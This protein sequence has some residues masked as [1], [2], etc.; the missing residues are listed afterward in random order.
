MDITRTSLRVL[1]LC[2]ALLHVSSAVADSVAPAFAIPTEAASATVH[3][4]EGRSIVARRVAPGAV[5]LDGVMNET[6]W[7]QAAP[8]RELRR[9]RPVEDGRPGLGDAEFRL[10]YDRNALY[11]G[12]RVQQP[13]G[14]A[15][16]QIRPRDD[17][18]ND[19]S[20]NIYLKSR[21]A[22]GDGY[23]FRINPLGIKKDIL[24]IGYD[25]TFGSWD[26]VW[27]AATSPLPAG[28]QM[29]VR[30]PFR[31]LR[32][33]RDSRNELRIG[34]GVNSGALGQLDL[35][36]RFSSERAHHLDQLGELLG[37]D[38]IDDGHR[39]DILPSVVFRYG[40]RGQADDSFAFDDS[41]VFRLRRPG[42]I[43]LGLD[44]LYQM[45]DSV[46]MGLAL[47]PD[48]SQV[49]ADPDQ[50]DYNLR[51]PL[52]LEETRPFFL[53]AL[54]TFDTPI[55]LLYT[56]S[57][58]DPVAG[59]R[60]TGHLGKTT[61]SL[62]SAWDLDPP[63]SRIR[64]DPSVENPV[65][66]GFEAA[67]EDE[68]F[69]TVARATVDLSRT[70]RVGAFFANKHLR[71]TDGGRDANNFLASVD[72]H[73]TLGNNYTFTGQ[74]GVSSA[75]AGGEDALTG[76]LGYLRFARDGR[77]LSLL[78]HSTYVSDEFRAETSNFSRVGYIPSL[79]QIAY[80]VEIERGGLVYVQPS[81]AAITNHD[82]GSFDL[83]DYSV[84]PALGLQFAG[85]TSATASVESGEEFYNGRR[86]DIQRATMTLAT[87]P[88]AWLDGSI[89]FGTGDQINYD[90]S[91]DFLGTSHEGSASLSL[92]PSLQAQLEL[93]Y[94]KSLFSRPEEPGFESNVDILR[95]KAVYSFDRKWTLRFISQ[96][97]TYSDSLQSNLLLAYLHSPGTAV[98]IGYRDDEPLSD[99]STVVVDRHLFVKLSYL[100]WL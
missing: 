36:P 11:I 82:D 62:L 97:N 65:M 30:I 80:R 24:I 9:A 1:I 7:Q 74:A 22:G 75:G 98:Y 56:R 20:I 32:I 96:L 73:F 86:F 15:R 63:P 5:E 23:V 100:S 57:I 4:E 77:R 53:E 8:V 81:I 42:Y 68:A 13:P 28:Y 29:E 25:Q 33:S 71:A 16:A 67:S 85:N 6:D 60:M 12:V 18:G 45:Q 93:R 26:A 78:A 76:G 40:G 52:L 37:V 47:N 34:F 84:A 49:E 66:S 87:A 58:N 17:L 3:D 35:W 59:A 89:S 79:A 88:L 41:P 55:P 54:S 38:D 72:A 2:S 91:D 64:F 61:V 43:D 31:I 90:P 21:S 51:Y 50:L 10:L 92:R 83:I 70:A 46:T 19:D 99:A 14:V 27:D 95:L 39:L 44:L 94:L 69:S 48:F